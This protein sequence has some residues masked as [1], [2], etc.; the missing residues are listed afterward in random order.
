MERWFDCLNS[1]CGIE[2]VIDND[3]YESLS[4]RPRIGTR[5]ELP[6]IFMMVGE[7]VSGTYCGTGGG[8][9]RVIEPRAAD[10]DEGRCRWCL[11]AGL[12]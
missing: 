6:G 4:P 10:D 8:S 5:G 9:S 11:C 1:G 12:E 3:R 7:S 2:F